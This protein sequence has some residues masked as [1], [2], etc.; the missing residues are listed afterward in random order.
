MTTIDFTATID[1]HGRVTLAFPPG[2]EPPPSVLA[3][4]EELAEDGPIGVAPCLPPQ[5][6]EAMAQ[7]LAALL[8]G[9]AA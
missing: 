1:A 7:R 9:G 8:L 4:V 2:V 3:L 5:E 6:V